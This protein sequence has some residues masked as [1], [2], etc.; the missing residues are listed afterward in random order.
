MVTLP[1]ENTDQVRLL[2]AVNGELG[3]VLSTSRFDEHV[4]QNI[5]ALGVVSRE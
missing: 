1:R 4:L 3:D 5:F 2:N